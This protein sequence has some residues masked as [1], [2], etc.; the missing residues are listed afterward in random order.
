MS[1]PEDDNASPTR[2]T[3]LQ[4]ATGLLLPSWAVAQQAPAVI[5]SDAERPVAAQGLQLGD[6]LGG[7]VMVWS[8]ADLSLIH[9]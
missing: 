3:V 4:A 6:P 8:R 9:I 1:F 5:S 7:S 2:R